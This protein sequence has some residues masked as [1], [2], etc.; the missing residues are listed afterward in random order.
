MV[1]GIRIEEK[2]IEAIRNWPEPRSVRDIELF[3]GFANFY[4]RV[5]KSF[6]RI[7]AS[8]T[9]ML[10]TIGNDNLD[11]QAS[12]HKEK[13]DRIAGASSAS[14][15][16]VDGSIKNLSIAAKLAK[17]KKPKLTKP[18]K[19]DLVKAQNFSKANSFGTDFL[20]PKAKKAFIY[21]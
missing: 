13:Q 19:S 20:T 2:K 4:G 15:G 5:I 1:Q 12:G 11:A 6:K 17:S 3:L 21:L 8:L 18:K 16:R 10:Q 14:G 7:V 9:L